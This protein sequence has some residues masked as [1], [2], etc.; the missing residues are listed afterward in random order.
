MANLELHTYFRSSAAYRVR[1]A[2]NLKGLA[3]A[4]RFV[5]LAKGEQRQPGYRALNPQGRVPTLVA[6]GLALAQSMAIVEYL[7]E[8]YPEPPL[9][10]VDRLDRA[11]ARMLAQ[12]VACDIH[13]LNNLRVLDYLKDHCGQDEATRMAWMRHWIGSGFEA[14]E[15]HLAALRGRGRYCVGDAPS[16]ADVFLVPQVY[17][18]RRFCCDMQPFPRI[19]G[20]E[21]HCLS[22]PAFR[23]AAPDRQLPPSSSQEAAFDRFRVSSPRRFP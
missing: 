2:L 20:I 16:V 23:A 3:Y 12:I 18:A 8:A 5:H 22:L 14:F 6:D 17:N 19:R 1:I 11:R 21:E 10:P 15:A 4:P 9:L 13:P 7:D